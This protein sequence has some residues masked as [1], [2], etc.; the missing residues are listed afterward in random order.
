MKL[1]RHKLEFDETNPKTTYRS[2]YAEFVRIYKN[3]LML[4]ESEAKFCY[5]SCFRSV[6]I[7][8]QVGAIDRQDPNMSLADLASKIGGIISNESPAFYILKLKKLMRKPR[9]SVGQFGFRTK[10]TFD[11]AIPPEEFYN[12]VNSVAYHERL[13]DAFLTGLNS[14]DLVRSIQR[15]QIKTM[16]AAIVYANDLIRAEEY[17]KISKANAA[18]HNLQGLSLEKEAALVRKKGEEVDNIQTT[19]PSDDEEAECMDQRPEKQVSKSLCFR[20]QKDGHWA[21]NCPMP[22]SKR[23]KDTQRCESQ[24]PKPAQANILMKQTP[25]EKRHMEK[26]RREKQRRMAG[27][28]NLEDSEDSDELYQEPDSD[29]EHSDDDNDVNLQ[30]IVDFVNS[31]AVKKGMSY[32]GK[33]KRVNLLSCSASTD[34]DTPTVNIIGLGETIL[35]TGSEV[36]LIHPKA[37][38]P[39]AEVQWEVTMLADFTG[40]EKICTQTAILA[41][42]RSGQD[43]ILSDNG[44]RVKFV[45]SENAPK[46]LL[47]FRDMQVLGLMI[48][49]LSVKSQSQHQ[50]DESPEC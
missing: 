34:A 45:V 11:E 31:L 5:I 15:R 10:V 2:F 17:V 39:T 25:A 27:I 16:D 1:L 12:T 35:D 36:S 44:L 28:N 13:L 4:P 9:E 48:P 3:F 32:S 19:H 8:Q 18:S 40:M 50:R 30:A 29:Q 22:K 23:D 41:M 37:I 7:R 38:P 47:S 43:I 21:R 46:P 24:P 20:C 6:E 42:K 26:Q 33:P 14:P 49:R